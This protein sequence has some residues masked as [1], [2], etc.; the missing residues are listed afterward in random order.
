MYDHTPIASYRHLRVGNVGGEY[1][2]WLLEGNQCSSAGGF[3]S[4]PI[5]SGSAPNS[6]GLSTN[7]R[8]VGDSSQLLN[9]WGLSTILN[10]LGLS[11]QCLATNR[12]I[13]PSITEQLG[14]LQNYRTVGNKLYKSKLMGTL[15][16]V[17][18]STGA[19][20]LNCLN[21]WAVGDSPHWVNSWGLSTITEQLG[22]L[23]NYW[24]VGDSPQLLN[25]SGTNSTIL[26]YWGLSLQSPASTG[27]IRPQLLNSWGLSTITEQ[28]GTLHYYWTVGDSPQLL[29]SWGLSRVTK[30]LHSTVLNSWGLPLKRPTTKR[31]GGHSTIAEQSGTF[32]T[33][34]LL[35]TLPLGCSR[36][37]EQNAHK[38]ALYHYWAVRNF[39]GV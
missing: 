39:Q 6:W 18:P 15:S 35:A 1:G 23:L 11:L 36:D 33:S 9:S 7:Y 4:N 17:Q 29:S 32:R 34:K 24:T 13:T 3:P 25:K 31:S 10:C 28:R 30:Q 5:L 2:Y 21:Y 38:Y 19:I 12:S 37:Q 26:N 14:T 27:A 22:D 8:T 20:C 16:I